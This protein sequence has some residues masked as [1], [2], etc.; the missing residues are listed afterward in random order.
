MYTNS[1]VGWYYKAHSILTVWLLKFYQDSNAMIQCK[2][3]N[4]NTCLQTC[5]YTCTL[6]DNFIPRHIDIQ[7]LKRDLQAHRQV[8]CVLSKYFG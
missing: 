5:K 6:T 2:L 3:Q 8:R 1:T 7:V 4:S